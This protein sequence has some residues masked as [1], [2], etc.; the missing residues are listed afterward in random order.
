MTEPSKYNIKAEVNQIVETNTGTVI[1]KQVQ[2]QTS[3][4]LTDALAQLQ[5]L[6][7]QFQQPPSPD[8]IDVEFE[9]IKRK[10]PQRWLTIMGLL[11]VAFAGGMEAIKIVEPRL[12][13]PYEA[14]KRLYEI[15]DR[16]RKQ[17]PGR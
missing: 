17:L 9:E 5:Q 13:I 8:V 14:A 12:G 15:Y 16:N 1:G 7:E 4:E 3:P 6:I 10:Q 11:S 2:A